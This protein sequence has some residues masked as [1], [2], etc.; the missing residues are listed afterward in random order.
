MMDPPGAPLSDPAY[1]IPAL[2]E[3]QDLAGEMAR[4]V[5]YGACMKHDLCW[6]ASI[7]QKIFKKTSTPWSHWHDT[8]VA[9]RQP[10]TKYT[11]INY[12]EIMLK[13]SKKLNMS[14]NI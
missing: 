2:L 9:P 5:G 14:K 13:T 1:Y 10:G 12:P 3:A 11:I 4:L 7:L 8:F 6:V